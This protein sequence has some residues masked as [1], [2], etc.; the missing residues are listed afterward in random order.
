MK[1]GGGGPLFPNVY[2][3][4]LTK[5]NFFNQKG[6]LG[7][8]TQNKSL[9]CFLDEGLPKGGWGS[10]IWEK[11]PKNPVFFS[12]G[13]PYMTLHHCSVK[14]PSQMDVVPWDEHWIK[15]RHP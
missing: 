9:N 4:I 2:I 11:L 10:A 15:G 13:S 5:S 7:P 14:T 8:L 1:G 12:E 3:R 6:S